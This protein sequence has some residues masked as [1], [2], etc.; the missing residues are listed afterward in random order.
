MKKILIT[1][2]TGFTGRHLLDFLRSLGINRGD[3]FGI[4]KEGPCG[5]TGFRFIKSDLSDKLQTLRVLKKVKPGLIFHLAGINFGKKYD[6]LLCSNILMTNNLLEALVH[7]GLGAR[8]LIIG[9][10]AE[11]GMAGGSRKPINESAPIMPVTPYGVSKA[12]QSMLALQYSQE[13]GLYVVI[14]RPFN[15]IGPG[16]TANLVCGSIVSQMKRSCAGKERPGKII[17]GNLHTKRDFIDV[18]DAV[19]AYWQLLTCRK[20][21]SGQVFNIG[22][23]RAHSVQ[24]VIDKLSKYCGRKIEIEQRVS[25]VRTND[26]P[27]QVA[28]VRKIKRVIGWTGKIPIERSLKEMYE[29]IT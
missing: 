11:Y 5:A 1:G 6:E 3:I 10:A 9:S 12:A 28:D 24:D 23:G 7:S 14:A 16:Q 27:F 4:D 8:I 22:S 29:S 26:I 19:R 17:V 21:I 25:K 20:D 18:R 15:L 13:F 2:V